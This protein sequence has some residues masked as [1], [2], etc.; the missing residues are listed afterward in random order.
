[1]SL[2]QS[3]NKSASATVDSLLSEIDQEIPPHATQ[4]IPLEEVGDETME[5]VV[6]HNTRSNSSIGVQDFICL[7]YTSRCV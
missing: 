6:H 2:I 7:L 4:Q 1:M 3:S 5:K